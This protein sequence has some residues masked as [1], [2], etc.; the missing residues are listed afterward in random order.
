VVTPRLSVPLVDLNA[1]SIGC[2][3]GGGDDGLWM[4]PC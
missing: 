4:M 2:V 1:V 3:E